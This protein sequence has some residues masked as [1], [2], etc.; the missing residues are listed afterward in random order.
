MPEAETFGVY[1]TIDEVLALTG[2]TVTLPQCQAATALIKNST[3][4]D[5]DKTHT[6]TS[7]IYSGDGK[8]WLDLGYYPLIKITSVKISDSAITDY[9]VPH[10]VVSND[11][12]IKEHDGPDGYLFRKN[13]W[14]ESRNN[15]E[16]SFTYGY[17]QVPQLIKDV[18]S[19]VAALLKNEVLKNIATEKI[20]DY[21]VSYV[22]SQET[23]DKIDRLLTLLPK[24]S[25]ITAVGQD[26]TLEILSQAERLIT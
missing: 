18:A 12:G 16:V 8:Y 9:R 1:T 10:G 26:E 5:Y 20:G 25:K 15:I 11:S 23:Q 4:L 24:D 3:G 17:A 2:V 22:S 6:I 14:P 13:T 21:S 7:K 19:R